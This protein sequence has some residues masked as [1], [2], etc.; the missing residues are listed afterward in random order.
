MLDV[1]GAKAANDGFDQLA[2]EVVGDAF[3]ALHGKVLALGY[4]APLIVLDQVAPL[5]TVGEPL[6]AQAGLPQSRGI[7]PGLIGGMEH[8]GVLFIACRCLHGV[9]I[10]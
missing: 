3:T 5:V 10:V 2:D 7:H 1:L 6:V 8:T 9:I 4:H